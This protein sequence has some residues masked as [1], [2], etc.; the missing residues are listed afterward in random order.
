MKIFTIGYGGRKPSEFIVLL[1][2]KDIKT[3]IDVRIKPVGYMAFFTKAK[4]SEK[5]IEGLLSR[6]GIGYRHMPELGNQFINM[7]N[8][9]DLFQKYVENQEPSWIT[10]IS[11]ILGPCCLMCSEKKN[12]ECHRAIITDYLSKKGWE[13]EHI[14]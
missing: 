9:R 10:R 12:N 13:I 6:E 11:E 4:S 5:G 3:I 1:K 2:Q 14:E 8:W 7:S